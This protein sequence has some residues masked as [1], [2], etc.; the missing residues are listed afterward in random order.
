[1]ERRKFIRNGSLT[2][3]G[4]TAISGWFC[5]VAEEVDRYSRNRKLKCKMEK[6]V[7]YPSQKHIS[8]E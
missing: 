7:Q 6:K 3:F 2:G 4:L 5:P 1:M 8:K